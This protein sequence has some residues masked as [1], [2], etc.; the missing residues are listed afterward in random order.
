MHTQGTRGEQGCTRSVPRGM[1]GEE[2]PPLA[3][4][5]RKIWKLEPS[6]KDFDFLICFLLDLA[7]F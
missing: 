4:S 2:L 7:I 6:P 3:A 1:P 5:Q